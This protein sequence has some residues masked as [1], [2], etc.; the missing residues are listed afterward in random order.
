MIEQWEAML[1]LF[2]YALND[3]AVEPNGISPHRLV[4]GHNPTSPLQSLVSPD[5]VNSDGRTIVIDQQWVIDKTASIEKLWAF[6]RD[7]QLR[8]AERMKDRYD[9][10]RQN[11]EL[12][13]GD[14]VLVSA[15]T[16]PLLRQY[17]KQAEKW[18]GPYVVKKK[19]SDN[20]YAI[21]DLPVGT[22][23]RQ[24][25]GFLSKY[26]ASPSRFPN[27]PPLSVNL[28][29]LK[30]GEWE[31]EV[32]KIEDMK[33]DRRGV[34]KFLVYWIGYPKPEWKSLEELNHCKE[35]LKDYFDRTAE[36]IP[37]NVQSFLDE[38]S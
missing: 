1:L 24:H 15:K 10:H 25:S 23:E 29:E 34:T 27:R 3:S 26:K 18:Y 30:D 11:L 22:P 37:P 33:V 36:E 4:F 38:D 17:R 12:S 5:A 16:H 9:Q 13:P 14:L 32:E 31:W 19:V 6:V 21:A 20:A 2:Q 35:V 8:C 28:P 7:N